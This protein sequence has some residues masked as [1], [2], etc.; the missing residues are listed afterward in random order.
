M[1]LFDDICAEKP[2]AMQ[3]MGETVFVETPLYAAKQ[4]VE[5][6]YI[7]LPL[8]ARL[9]GAEKTFG[10]AAAL[11]EDEFSATIEAENGTGEIIG[12][13]YV[14]L[15]A[16]PLN[17]SLSGNL[18]SGRAYYR[19][20]IFN[21]KGERT[22]LATAP[23]KKYSDGYLEME[24]C[25]WETLVANALQGAITTGLNAVLAVFD[26]KQF[27][28]VGW[29]DEPVTRGKIIRID[30]NGELDRV[31]HLFHRQQPLAAKDWR[32]AAEGFGKQEADKFIE[33]INHGT[34]S[35]GNISPAGHLIDFDTVCAVKT[36]SP[37]FS[38]T[39]WH[40]D[41]Y[42]GSEYLGQ[43]KL[44]AAMATDKALAPAGV[45]AAALQENMHLSF[46]HELI[47]R[48]PELMGFARG[49]QIPV[50]L[51]KDL[52]DVVTS[53]RD[54]ARKGYRQYEELSLKQANA[55]ALGLF[56]FSLLFRYYPLLKRLGLFAA[57]DALAQI[58]DHDTWE[59]PYKLF[60]E[61]TLEPIA[62]EHLD[63]V[64]AAIGEHFITDD[65]S[66]SA[67]RLSALRFIKKYDRLF[68]ALLA[69]SGELHTVVEARAYAV[70]EDRFFLFPAYTLSFVIAVNKP[71][72]SP[73][74][75]HRMIAAL[76]D[77]C[78]R[79]AESP[80]LRCDIRLFEAGISFTELRGDGTYRLGFEFFETPMAGDFEGLTIDKIMLKASDTNNLIYKSDA[81]EVE[82]FSADF[83]RKYYL[84]MPAVRA[85]CSDRAEMSS[86]RAQA[87]KSLFEV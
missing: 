9:F 25:I 72:F 55:A 28:D 54:L 57:E 24:R 21:V 66:F 51:Q 47:T 73:E 34:W 37:Q 80:P 67:L 60:D 27:C 78:R 26:M 19:G 7:N 84:Q 4:R 59:D 50:A 69:T 64:Y 82:D 17:L 76:V 13:A 77:S 8:F 16:D 43:Q 63:R 45:A 75:R 33:R 87:M 62:R 29:R 2:R 12:T 56:D 61:T 86:T 49:M 6:V 5:A 58:E 10:E 81:L 85:L 36:R 1:S 22:P 53:F 14:D 32:A 35:A 48:F 11:L 38:S 46:D 3:R 18:G 65:D 15:Q 79:S 74:R 71:G 30:E 44:L 31:T 20:G 70:N 83:H 41:N 39:R 52:A 42:F 68:T 23:T 40:P